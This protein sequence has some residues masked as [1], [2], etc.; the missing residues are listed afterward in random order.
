MSL[1]ND[2]QALA[3][4]SEEAA[5]RNLSLLIALG[6]R[7]AD[8][9]AAGVWDLSQARLKG[10]VDRLTALAVQLSG[11]AVIAGLAEVEPEIA[12][13]RDV[14]DETR[15]EIAKIKDVSRA[16]TIF[17]AVLDVG[18]AVVSLASGPTVANVSALAAKAKALKTALEPSE[19]TA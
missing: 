14:T 11:H 12:K 1:S 3:D 8:P 5:Q 10:Q 18:L 13:I 9:L 17:G 4:A 16:L 19:A 7:P 15:R 6:P 2:L